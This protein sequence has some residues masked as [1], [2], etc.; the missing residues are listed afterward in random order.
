MLF[1]LTMIKHQLVL[2]LQLIMMLF[3]LTIETPTSIIIA[4]WSNNVILSSSNNNVVP[5]S[6]NNVILSYNNTLLLL[7]SQ[8]ILLFIRITKHKQ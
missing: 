8:I 2:L 4:D 3:Q 7:Q 6:N 1:Q 5:I